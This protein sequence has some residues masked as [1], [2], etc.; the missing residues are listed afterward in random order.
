MDLENKGA[1]ISARNEKY[2]RH[3]QGL[4]QIPSVS[5]VNDEHTDWSRFDELHQYLQ[6]TYPMIYQ[7]LELTVIGKASLL[8][9]WPSENPDRKPVLLMAHQD[10]VPAG[11]EEQW[12]HPPFAG[13]VEDGFLWGRGSEDCKSLLSAEMDAVEELLEEH[14]KPS[15]DIYLSF[16]HNEEVQCTPDKKGSILAAF[17]SA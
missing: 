13:E 2:L 1:E 16:G 6:T 10:V 8:F 17:A 15:F 5:S 14:F 12:S 7:K 4:V 9:R 11:R 3:L